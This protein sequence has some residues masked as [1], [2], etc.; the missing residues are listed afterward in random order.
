VW[1]WTTSVF[2][3]HERVTGRGMRHG[4]PLRARRAVPCAASPPRAPGRGVPE[5]APC[6]RAHRTGSSAPRM[7]RRRRARETRRRENSVA[8]VTFQLRPPHGPGR[9]EQ[10]EPVPLGLARLC[11]AACGPALRCEDVKRH[12]PQ[13]VLLTRLSS[14]TGREVAGSDPDP[15]SLSRAGVRWRAG[16]KRR[17][18]SGAAAAPHPSPSGRKGR[19]VPPCTPSRSFARPLVLMSSL[20]LKWRVIPFCQVA[21]LAAS[22]SP[23]PAVQGAS[24]AR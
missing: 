6:P 16:L 4:P 12:L 17:F 14:P 15:Q 5:R 3:Q 9:I 23:T 8:R 13:L 20:Y 18:N 1:A 7:S 22:H 21:I 24:A 2:P 19:G 10:F 11:V